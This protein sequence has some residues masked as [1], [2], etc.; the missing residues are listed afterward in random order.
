MLTLGIETTADRLSL[1]LLE[2]DRRASGASW[3]PELCE[4]GRAITLWEK[5]EP[6][7]Q[8]R[9]WTQGIKT[10]LT[11]TG[12]TF[13]RIQLV[14]VSCGPGRFTGVRVGITMAKTLGY[15]LKIP[16]LGVS[17]LDALAWQ[18]VIELKPP[19]A[20]KPEKQ[21]I[22][23]ILTAIRDEVFTAI[24]IFHPKTGK[25]ERRTRRLWLEAGSFERNI[26]AWAKTF[27][28]AWVLLGNGLK[29]K[30][31]AFLSILPSQARFATA[32]LHPLH[33]DS[34]A[35]YALHLWETG[36]RPEPEPLYIKKSHVELSH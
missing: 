9:H 3:S 14:G 34:V 13:S 10:L 26:R 12:K 2:K 29:G 4:G 18:W 6:L 33:A 1:A 5:K 28:G 21:I 20:H 22:C 31:D 30:K 25:L 32:S 23:P 17:T 27:P 11:K 19:H 36:K 35:S 16:V 8:D 15:A 7:Q 24:Y